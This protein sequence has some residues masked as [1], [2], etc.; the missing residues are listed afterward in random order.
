MAQQNIP[1]NAWVVRAGNDNE[2][3][4]RIEERRA[5][6]IGWQRMGDL[7]GLETREEFKTR[8]REKLPQHSSHR[9]NINAGQLFRFA[10]KVLVGDYMLT[11]DKATRELLVGKVTSDIENRPNTFGE[12]YPYVRSIDWLKRISRDDFSTAAR[13]SLGSSLT[14]F[15]MNHH[16]HE[17]HRLATG[18]SADT[19]EVDEL[20]VEE[21][22]FHDEVKSQADE[23]IADLVSS[24]DPYEFQD[25]AAGVLQA[26]GFRA[27]SSP[28]GRDRGVDII[29]HPDPLGFGRPRIKVQVKHREAKVGGPD[30]RNF[31]A[32]V[33][34]DEYGLFVSTGGFSPDAKIEADKA[35]TTITLLDRDSFIELMLEHY[36]ELDPGFQAKIPL[37][38]L[39]VPVTE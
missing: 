25:L 16:L 26:M 34:Q 20:P 13:S 11:Y 18:E 37:R 10:R 5:V 14:V 3:I 38:R 23:L 36:E 33:D 9:V 12:G 22:P 4:N 21:V 31:V 28:P 27:T 2:L 19:P 15:R 24:L 8:Y 35:R 30:M 1:K 29:A 39:W 17:I 7:S 32:T 6:A